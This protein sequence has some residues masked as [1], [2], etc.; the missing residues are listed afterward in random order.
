MVVTGP[1]E[2][3]AVGNILVQAVALGRLSLSSEACAIVR[4]L[5]DAVTFEPGRRDG[6][7]E[8]HDRLQKRQTPYG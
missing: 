6:W 7:D 3:T 2:A 5:F 8:A 4:A 1:V